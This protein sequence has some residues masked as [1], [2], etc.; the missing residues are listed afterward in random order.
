MSTTF[1]SAQ[2]NTLVIPPRAVAQSFTGRMGV[3]AS[4]LSRVRDLHRRLGYNDRL[5]DYSAK[6]M[7]AQ[8]DHTRKELAIFEAIDTTGFP[9]EEA[10]NK[11]L[12]VRRLREDVVGARFHDWQMPVD[13]MNGVHLSYASMPSGMPFQTVKDYENYIARLHELPRV[14]DQITVDMQLGLNNHLMPPK[15]LLD[16]VAV[17]AQD[18]ADKTDQTSPF[19]QP[20]LKFPAGISDATRHV[21]GK[22]FF[23]R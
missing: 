2:N 9:D 14:F 15:Y 11:A 3:P 7:A 20:V 22:Q 21:S 4:N 8:E 1:L 23:R 17:Q 16:K 6:A 12:M 5:S 19:T 18:I 13:Q 10:L